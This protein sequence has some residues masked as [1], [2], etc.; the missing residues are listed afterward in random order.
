[1]K[2]ATEIRAGKPTKQAAA[3]AYSVARKDAEIARFGAGIMFVAPNNT[4][5]FLKRGDGG[6]RPGEWCFPGGGIEEP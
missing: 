3:I 2:R 4:A 1:M 5:L 6:D